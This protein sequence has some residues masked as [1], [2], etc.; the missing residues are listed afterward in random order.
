MLACEH[1]S[2]VESDHYLVLCKFRFECEK[3]RTTKSEI[4]VKQ[5][6]GG[7]NHRIISDIPENE[8]SNDKHKNE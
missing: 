6:F 3:S 8:I 1:K 2:T 5:R 7:K 4:K